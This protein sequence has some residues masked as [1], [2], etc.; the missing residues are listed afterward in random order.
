MPEIGVPS[1]QP[2]GF[3]EEREPAITQ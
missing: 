2:Q 1:K 3:D